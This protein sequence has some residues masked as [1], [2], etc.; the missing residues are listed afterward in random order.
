MAIWT[1]YYA[2]HPLWVEH[3]A[4]AMSAN[5]QFNEALLRQGYGSALRSAFG[6][7]RF[8]LQPA[9]LGLVWPRL[10][11]WPHSH[12][13]VTAPALY[14]CLALLARFVRQ[15]TGSGFLAI[16]AAGVFCSMGGLYSER[17]GVGVPWPDYQSM[18][19][20]S[21][22]V[23]SM[24]LYAV[25]TRVGWLAL[26]GAFVS[27][28][29]LARDTGSVYAA[30]VCAPIL[31]LLVAIEIR[32]G[33]GLPAV[34]WRLAACGI[35]ALPAML[36][37]LHKVAWFHQYYMSPNGTTLRQPLA[38]AAQSIWYLF[39]AFSGIITIVGLGLLMLSGLVLWPRRQ[40]NAA[41]ILVA[42]WPLSF[43]AFLLVNGYTSDITKEVMYIAPGLVCA[44]ATLGGGIDVQ[45]RTARALVAAVLVI[46]AIGA[47][48]SAL[49]AFDRASHPSADALRLKTDQRAVA[50]AVASVPQRVTWQSFSAYDWGTVISALTFFDFGHYQ[51]AD[52]RLFH[53]HKNYWDGNFPDM[54]LTE[55]EAY[56][57][58]Q[59]EQRVDLA[60]VLAHPDQKPTG[61]E[62]YSFSIASYVAAHIQAD[63]A[64]I[65]YREVNSFVSGPLVLYLNARRANTGFLN[66]R[67]GPSNQIVDQC[68]RDRQQTPAAVCRRVFGVSSRLELG[69]KSVATVSRREGRTHVNDFTERAVTLMESR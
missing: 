53:N 40:W 22:A 9:L 58:E 2:N 29:T 10:L 19:F 66:D 35:P 24:G 15:R 37:L 49:Q 44:V 56:V 26:A 42:Y 4:N 54:N 43:F 65:R 31:L 17:N 51:P 38:V 45:S 41:D 67:A 36:L 46:C 13:L 16:A 5:L 50:E 8:I 6:N 52:N 12:I 33:R 60:I 34:F 59:T 14:L 7:A 18:F 30:V 28:A 1:A 63:S 3:A 20:L 61:M 55:L 21:S 62:D 32:R 27:L 68:D 25:E 69:F 48:R 64:W 23:L 47:G 11:W 39:S 57:L